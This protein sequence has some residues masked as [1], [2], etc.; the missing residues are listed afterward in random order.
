MVMKMTGTDVQ[1]VR[2]PHR[3]V[4]QGPD[5]SVLQAAAL[6]GHEK[7]IHLLLRPEY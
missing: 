4:Y 6:G 7:I 2:L 1:H 3:H 5:G